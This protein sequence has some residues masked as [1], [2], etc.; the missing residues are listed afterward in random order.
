MQGAHSHGPGGRALSLEVGP[1]EEGVCPPELLMTC[2]SSKS[3]QELVSRIWNFSLKA[4][5]SGASE[6]APLIFQETCEQLASIYA[7]AAESPV[8][9][10]GLSPIPHFPF[11]GHAVLY[12]DLFCITGTGIK[13]L[14]EPR[15]MH[16]NPL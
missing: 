13:K 6:S 7:A 4:C 16:R 12:Y 15:R 5:F 8:V 9:P 14:R 10:A 1:L 2:E 3:W 11:G